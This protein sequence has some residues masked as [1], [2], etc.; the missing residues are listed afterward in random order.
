MEMAALS[1]LF[2]PSE[3]HPLESSHKE[4]SLPTAPLFLHVACRV[5]A[6]DG[7][8]AEGEREREGVSMVPPCLPVCL[9]ELHIM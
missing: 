9:S 3:P 2:S 7:Q 8:E 6:H 4:P 1:P 5:Q